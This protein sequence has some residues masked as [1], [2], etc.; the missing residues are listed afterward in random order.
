MGISPFLDLLYN[1]KD[2][3]GRWQEIKLVWAV[4]GEEYCG[5]AAAVDLQA[6]LNPKP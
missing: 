4:R 1:L 2:L 5:L 3:R 6:A